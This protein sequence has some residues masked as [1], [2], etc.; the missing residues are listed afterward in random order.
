[1]LSHRKTHTNTRTM[2]NFVQFNKLISNKLCSVT[3]FTQNTSKLICASTAN[4]WHPHHLSHR[5]YTRTTQKRWQTFDPLSRQTTGPIVSRI[6]HHQYS[7]QSLVQCRLYSTDRNR[8][9]Q[10]TQSNNEPRLPELMNTPF[11]VWP[12]VIQTI[13]NWIFVQLIIKP[14]MDKE[15]CL[16]EFVSGSKQALEVV[17]NRLAT[18]D[19]KGLQGLMENDT[20]STVQKSIERMTVAQRSALAVNR[21]D[22]Y[23]SF[24]YQV[25]IILDDENEDDESEVQRRFVEITMI[26]HTLKDR[27]MVQEH[28]NELPWNIGWVNTSA[29][30]HQSTY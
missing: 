10:Q 2:A 30:I 14:Y 20:L 24:P 1:M 28:R 19:F 5:T 17:S 16:K 4:P 6:H 3:N 9:D 29:D 21:D 25:G 18:S 12:S 26:F 22:V 23:F 27:A 15:F 7:C 11:I 8:N 13:K